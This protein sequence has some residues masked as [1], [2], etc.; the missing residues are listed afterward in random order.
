MAG[1]MRAQVGI[2]HLRGIGKTHL[3]CG[4]GDLASLGLLESGTF[5]P[6]DLQRQT[7]H[8]LEDIAAACLLP[9]LHVYCCNPSSRAN[10]PVGMGLHKQAGGI[11][12]II[13]MAR[14]GL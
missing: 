11:Q 9:L 6:S 1:C 13:V 5:G 3:I 4:V 10:A 7:C 12:C 2:G 14:L 8:L